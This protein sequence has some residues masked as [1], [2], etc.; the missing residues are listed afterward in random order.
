MTDR[1]CHRLPAIALA[2]AIA[3][4][5]ES[6]PIDDAEILEHTANELACVVSWTTD[7]PA[8]ARVEFGDGDEPRWFVDGDASGTEHEVT[9]IGMRPGTAYTLWAVSSSDS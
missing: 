6:P 4:G 7:E 3:G 8:S 5:C 1:R 2:L 9:V